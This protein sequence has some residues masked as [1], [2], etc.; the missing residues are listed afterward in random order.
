MKTTTMAIIMLL[1]MAGC[2]NRSTDSN[3]P[4]TGSYSPSTAM[5]NPSPAPQDRMTYGVIQAIDQMQRQDVGVGVMGAM[6]AGGTGGTPTDKVYRI[7]VRMN[8]G[9]SQMVVVE[10][11]PRYKIGDR[12]RYNNGNVQAY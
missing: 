5:A 10:S 9:S 4:S 1:A 6:A 2:A 11:E 3:T 7:T 12:V 8:D